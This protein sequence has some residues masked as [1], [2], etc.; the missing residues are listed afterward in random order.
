VSRARFVHLE[1]LIGRAVVTEDG[2]RV[3][4]VEEVRAERR[5]DEYEVTEYLLGTG[6]LLERLSLVPRLLGRQRRTYVVRWD[7]MDISRPEHPR[8]TCPIEELVVDGR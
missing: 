4:R 1:D 3:G 8:L 7:Q 6:A 2:R 5:G